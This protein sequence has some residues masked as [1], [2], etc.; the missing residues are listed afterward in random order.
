MSVG[1]NVGLFMWLRTMI[2]VQQVHGHPI[3]D[4]MR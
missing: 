3:R 2:S 4:V 1:V